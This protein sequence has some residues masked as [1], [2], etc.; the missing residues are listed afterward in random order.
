MEKEINNLVIYDGECALCNNS[1]KYILFFDKKDIFYFASN[2]SPLGKN[3]LDEVGT[4]T[5]TVLYK[6]GDEFFTKSEAVLSILRDLGGVNTVLFNILNIF[7]ERLADFFYDF[8]SG[9]RY[10]V[11]G[12]SKKKVCDISDEKTM[13]KILFNEL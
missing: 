2:T 9:V 6:R 11:F 5:D 10:S 1:V 3:I 8:V 7:P 13:N 4:K 12:K